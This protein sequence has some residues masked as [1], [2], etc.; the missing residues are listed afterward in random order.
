MFHFQAQLVKANVMRWVPA[1]SLR[2]GAN[3]LAVLT[4]YLFAPG[5]NNIRPWCFGRPPVNTRR[6]SRDSEDIVLPSFGY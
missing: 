3:K 5:G 1:E 4:V 2:R 6:L